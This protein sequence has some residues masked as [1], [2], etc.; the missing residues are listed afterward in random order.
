MDTYDHELK[1][2]IDAWVREQ[3]TASPEWEPE[4]YIT[5]RQHLEADAPSQESGS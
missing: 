5:I 3:L 1:R 2:K 4:R